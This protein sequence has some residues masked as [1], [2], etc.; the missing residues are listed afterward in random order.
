ME[1]VGIGDIARL[2]MIQKSGIVYSNTL[3]HH[4]KIFPVNVCDILRTKNEI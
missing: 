3:T 2:T 1:L 4:Q